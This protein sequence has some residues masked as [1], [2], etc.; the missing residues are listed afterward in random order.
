[1]N[2]MCMMHM[3]LSF[4]VIIVNYH[5]PVIDISIQEDTPHSIR[6][7]YVSYDSYSLTEWVASSCIKISVVAFGTV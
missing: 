6:L 7:A 5:H 2:V 3:Y 4:A 1:M